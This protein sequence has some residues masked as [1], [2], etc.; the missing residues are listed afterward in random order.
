MYRVAFPQAEDLMI[1]PAIRFSFVSISPAVSLCGDG[2]DAGAEVRVQLDLVHTD[3]TSLWTLRSQVMTA[4]QTFSPPAIN[5]STFEEFDG[6]TK[7]YRAS[8]DYL[9]HPSG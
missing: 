2:G 8:L 6:P 7:T 3:A 9:M 5:E 1:W 4:M